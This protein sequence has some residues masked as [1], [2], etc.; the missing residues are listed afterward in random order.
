MQERV[1]QFDWASTS[2][3][4][5]DLWPQ[6]LRTSVS[7]CLASRFPILIWWGPELI[8]IYNDAYAPILG[9]KE[10]HALGAPG[11]EVW[12]EI[13]PVIGPML[14]QV[15]NEGRATWSDDQLLLMERHGYQEE[16]YF[17]FSDSPSLDESGGVGGIFTAVFE[18]TN[19]VLG[20]RRLD[21]L[22]QLAARASIS[23]SVEEACLAAIE[24]FGSNPKDVPFGAIYLRR[25]DG[26]MHCVGSVGTP[27]TPQ[28]ESFSLDAPPQPDD[29]GLM[30]PLELAAEELPAGMLVV[31]CSRYRAL[32]DDYRSFFTLAAHHVST[33]IAD[34]R[35][36]E[37]ERQRAEALAELDRAK[38][39]FFSNVSHEFRTP[40]TLMLGPLEELLADDTTAAPQ[41][42]RVELAHRNAL[43]LL[44]LVNA[45]LDFSRI[46]AGRVDAA[47]E[48][49]DL[50]E[51]TAHLAGVFRSAIERAGLAL[52]VDCP[53]L[54]EPV[55]VDREQW[56]KI[57]LNLL[58]NALKFTFEG[59]I[60]VSLHRE[61]DRAVLTVRD[62]GTGI[63]AVELPHVFERFHRVKGARGRTFEGSGIGLALVQELTKLHG[64]ETGVT[65]VP[66]RG[67]AFTVAIPLGNAHLPKERLGAA[68]RLASTAVRSEAWAEEGTRWLE[69][70]G[71]P[72]DLGAAAAL[73]ADAPRILLADDNADMR[74]YIERLLGARYRVESVATGTAALAA[75][76]RQPPDLVLSD[77][78]MPGMDGF[79][80]LR[81]LRGHERTREL[82]VILLSAR[83][84]EESRVDG[85]TAGA[86]D[87]LVKPFSARELLAR[88]DAHLRL[89]RLRREAE[90]RI[91]E[92]A[93]TAPAI[94]WITDTQ[95]SCIFLSRGWFEFTGQTEAE[96]LG[97]GWLQAIHPDD[98]EAAREL[99]LGAL[100][101]RQPVSADY[102]I[103][104][105]D[106]EYRWAID[107]GR[108][109]YSQSGEFLG[110]I[111]SVIDITDR[112]L[113][114]EAKD[115]FLAT[116]SH[117]LRT[118]LTSGF[119]WA[120]LLRKGHD[121]Q[122]LETGLAAIEESLV[123]QTRLIDDLLD[124]SRIVS[125]KMHLDLQPVDVG[126]TVDAAVE[127]VRPAAAAKRIEIEARLRSVA[128]VSGDP[129]RL[130]QVFWNLLTNAI[131]FSPPDRR[132]EVELHRDEGA[133]VVTV[134]DFGEGIDTKFLPHVFDR[135]RQADA[136]TTRRHGGLGLG[137]AIVKS[138][139]D[140][141]GGEVRAESDGP[142]TGATFTVR[143]PLIEQTR[144]HAGSE[145]G[146]RGEATLHGLRIVVVDDDAAAREVMVA[147]LEGAGAAV[148]ASA[149][150]ADAWRSLQE[151]EP[152]LLV[153][154]LAM[155]DEDGY[156]L[157]RRARENGHTMPA[158]AVTAYV[159]PE[160]EQQIRDAGFVRHVAKPFDP[161]QLVRAAAAA[162]SLPD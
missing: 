50:S 97:F 8:K 33:A 102:R 129:S 124:V 31:E 146:P 112:K 74:E 76:Q 23:R 1:E 143:L 15:L 67:S 4:P 117:E 148:R 91:R 21:T 161:E 123:N 77:V 138:L 105:A 130:K 80:L 134:R 24:I 14:D 56:E 72:L 144:L 38:T 28:P 37:L 128:S 147:A 40:L 54:G 3:G 119:G 139:V 158:L 92:F 73:P 16:T 35:A 140:A 81:A 45:L 52:R 5:R 10:P 152:H 20:E 145:A 115:Q 89:Q 13:W 65:S 17:T 136:S 108:P 9:A 7:I 113:A 41:R 142:Q 96:A 93:D 121:E 135:F 132:I 150:A 42:D 57:V 103:R 71:L 153:S 99:F 87:Y 32:D 120:K 2:I 100:E 36:Y 131:K 141:H 26:L 12:P 88:V 22:R 107:S 82:P 94:L 95:G 133:A 51:L 84:G 55:W 11:R 126:S 75:A 48:P 25:D 69:G 30:L 122:L 157:L 155:P 39:E 151:W 106:G 83:A 43:R 149:S 19:R 34:A 6:S 47:Y 60:A 162:A 27:R 109:R 104:R 118:P 114:E 68:K 79:G 46:E 154:D 61:G 86:D 44:K 90:L 125:G 18:T 59:E 53:P 101:H 64:G 85:M 66:G 62:T 159:R 116:L 127:M 78:M 29:C 58:S 70:S 156:A 137:L 110:Y 98:R 160:D 63:P 49:V 111:G